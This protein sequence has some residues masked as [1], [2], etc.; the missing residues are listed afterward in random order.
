[1]KASI[2]APRIRRPRPIPDDLDRSKDPGAQAS[3]TARGRVFRARVVTAKPDSTFA[4]RA[5][6]P[7][8]RLEVWRGAVNAWTCDEMGHMNV[9]FYLA[10]AL[11]GLAGVALALGLDDA[12]SPKAP[13]RWK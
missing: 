7:E 12:Y 3:K 11:E 6:A 2:A 13:R 1:M 8:P 9:R 10:H 5:L 4:Q